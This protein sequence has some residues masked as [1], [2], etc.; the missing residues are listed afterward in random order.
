MA[1]YSPPKKNTA[2]VFYV[3]LVSQSNTKTFQANPTLASGDVKVAIDDGA[4]ANLATLPVVDADFTRRVKVSLSSDEMNGDNITV[5]FADASGAEWCDLTINLQTASK[6]FDDIA[7]QTSVDDLPTNAELTT[8]LG[9]ADDAV[10]AAIPS[11]TTIADAVLS[12]GVSNVEDTANTTSLAAV[13]LAMLESSISGTTWTIRKTGGSTFVAKTVTVDAS[14][15][16]I[17][18]V[19]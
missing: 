5:I 18:G 6:Q 4:P 7:T 11:A 1:S 15:D 12:R 2:F 13:I 10:L 3:S 16:P 14:A 8:A 9:T 19:T 17:T